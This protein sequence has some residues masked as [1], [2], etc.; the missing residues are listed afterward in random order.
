MPEMPAEIMPNEED[1]QRGKYLEFTIG[2]EVF[3]FEL[4]YVTE[5]VG[6]QKISDI[7]ERPD[8]VK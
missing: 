7:P 1:A 5:I 6:L 2:E 8:Y 3:G 4:Q